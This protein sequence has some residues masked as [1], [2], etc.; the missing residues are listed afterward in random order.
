VAFCFSVVARSLPLAQQVAVVLVD[1]VGYPLEHASRVLKVD[2]EALLRFLN[3]G[4]AELVKLFEGLCGL[5]NENAPCQHCHGLRD[6]S[7]EGRKGADLAALSLDA[8]TPDERMF[9]RLRVVRDAS[10]ELDRGATHRLH[11]FLGRLVTRVET[12]RERNETD[13]QLPAGKHRWEDLQD[14]NN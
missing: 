4:R 1:V 12:E 5:A 9:R 3:A 7:P 13:R 8:A 14:R 11:D 10:P 2:D 6:A